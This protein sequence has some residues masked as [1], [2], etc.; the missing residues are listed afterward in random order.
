MM[1][2]DTPPVSLIALHPDTPH[3]DLI[4]LMRGMRLARAS[5]EVPHILCTISG[6]DDDPRQL[7]DIPE[8]VDYLRRLTAVGFISDL[9]WSGYHDPS[10]PAGGRGATVRSRY[11]S[12]GRG[13]CA[14]RPRLR[15]NCSTSSKLTGLPQTTGRTGA[16]PKRECRD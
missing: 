8:V 15:A 6:Y 12:A 3:A 16:W 10:V 9:S 11:G 13:G 5:G 1:D 14:P 2:A 7:R 4:V